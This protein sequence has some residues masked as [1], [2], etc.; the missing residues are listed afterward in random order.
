MRRSR[1]CNRALDTRDQSFDTADTYANTA[2]KD[3]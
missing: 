3:P 2:G 1:R